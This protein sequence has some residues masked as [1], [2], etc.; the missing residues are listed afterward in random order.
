MPMKRL[1]SFFTGVT[2][3]FC[4]STADAH[5]QPTGTT[6]FQGPYSSFARG[7]FGGILSFPDGSSTAL[8]G[9]YRFTAGRTAVSIQGGFLLPEGPADAVFLVGIE[10]KPLVVSRTQNFPL[11]GSLV[12]GIGGNF[13]NGAEN[14]L[15]PIGITFGRRLQLEDSEVSIVPFVEPMGWLVA[16]DAT[17]HFA[18][19]LG[20]GAEFELTRAFDIRVAFG[21]GDV[22][23]ISF[24]AVWKR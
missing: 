2:L 17:D 6:T 15:F 20:A 5:G 11:D 21:L 13:G 12:F 1:P 7:E 23:G 16:G 3:A 24:S 10:A 22:D 8:E 14:I 18:F 19:S 9:M 4:L